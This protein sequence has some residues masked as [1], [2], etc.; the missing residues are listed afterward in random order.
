MNDSVGIGEAAALFGL[1][2]STL[3]WWESQGVLAPPERDG[4][5]RVYRELD[6]R[7]I[8]LAYLCCVTGGMPLE[9]AAVVASGNAGLRAWRRTVRG[10]VVRIEQQLAELRAA[11]GYLNH[12]LRCTTDDMARCSYLDADLVLNTPRGQAYPSSLVA[13]ARAG[14]SD[15]KRTDRAENLC[16]SCGRP[17]LQSTRGR[18]RKYCSHACQ[19]RAYRARRARP[20]TTENSLRAPDGAPDDPGMTTTPAPPRSRAD[21]T[22]RG[23]QQDRPERT[24]RPGA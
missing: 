20:S 13:A 7:R 1:S 2:P 6:L 19:Q 12:L 21:V 3:R 24:V 16:A 9:A 18:P 5:K 8:G 23:R 22:G 14:R 15:V 10:Q 4:G 11:H 17:V